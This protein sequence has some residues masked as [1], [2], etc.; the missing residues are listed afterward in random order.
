MAK[1]RANLFHRIKE[2]RSCP[3][4]EPSHRGIKKQ[5]PKLRRSARL[6][7]I[8]PVDKNHEKSYPSPSTT[9]KDRKRKR[10]QEPEDEFCSAPAEKK[11]RVSPIHHDEGPFG[12][13]AANSI[14]EN[15]INA[16]DHWRKE[17]SWPKEYFEME[18]TGDHLL[19][20][21]KS[22]SSVRR[23]QSD[24]G[25]T[26]PSSTTPS[27]QNP[28]EEKSTPYQHPGYPILLETKGSFMGKDKDGPRKESKDLCRNLLEAE[29]NVPNTSRF[30]DHI[31][32]STCQRIQGR[33]E[34]KVIQDITRLIVPSAEELAD[35]GAEHLE[36][37]IHDWDTRLIN[38]GL[39]MQAIVAVAAAAT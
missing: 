2:R 30:S 20:R 8:H 29:Q 27:D 18:R 28:R 35:F 1:H 10:Q 23:K 19:A 31:F 39:S 22:S 25:S 14:S 9:G 6:R 33:N 4:G 32:E 37:L 38:P 24:T 3:S 36:C 34:A 13:E 12:L 11:P 26:T 15:R 5:T 16:I 7:D 21:K 17:G